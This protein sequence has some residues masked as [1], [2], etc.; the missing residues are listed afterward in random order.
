MVEHA[1]ERPGQ[2]SADCSAVDIL[3][4]DPKEWEQ[5]VADA[6]AQ[7]EKVLRQRAEERQQAAERKPVASGPVA[8]DPEGPAH[9]RQF[10]MS[11]GT[12]N[13]ASQKRVSD[14]M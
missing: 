3:P 9:W 14:E 4:Y 5:R 1:P 2:S 12:G 11:P 13:D 6:R 10:S 7:R 8:D